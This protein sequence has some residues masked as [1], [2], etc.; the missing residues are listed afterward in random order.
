MSRLLE[1]S[2]HLD[3]LP[4]SIAL[5]IR[6]ECYWSAHSSPA[7]ALTRRPCVLHLGIRAIKAL[8]NIRHV[9]LSGLC[10]VKQRFPPSSFCHFFQSHP[11]H[12]PLTSVEMTSTPAQSLNSILHSNPRRFISILTLANSDISEN[13]WGD[14]AM[15]SDAMQLTNCFH[16]SSLSSLSCLGPCPSFQLP[17][18]SA[19]QF[20][21]VGRIGGQGC[22]R[23]TV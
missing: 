17:K 7:V 14:T 11:L 3:G 9:T 22:Y 1:L 13:S 4:G 20:P 2:C 19:N 16:S 23:G 5:F 18:L 21:G 8:Y 15:V 10:P 12:H 6:K